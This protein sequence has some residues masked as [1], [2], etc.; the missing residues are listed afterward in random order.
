MHSRIIR[1][2][3]VLGLLFPTLASAVTTADDK[4]TLLG[5][6]LNGGRVYA[7]ATRGSDVYVGGS[8]SKIGNVDAYSIAKWNGTEW[9]GVGTGIP[10]PGL[11]GEVRSLAFDK[12]GNLFA[13]GYFNKSMDGVETTGIIK[14]NGSSWSSMPPIPNDYAGAYDI[15]AIAFDANNNLYAGGCYFSTNKTLP[16]HIARWDGSQWSAVGSGLNNCVTSIAF[17]SNGKLFVGGSF[18]FNSQ[19]PGLPNCSNTSCGGVASWNGSIWSPIDAHFGFSVNAIAFDNNDHLYIS[20]NFSSVLIFTGREAG[21]YQLL[22]IKSLAKWS[23][24]RFLDIAVGTPPVTVHTESPIV[25]KVGQ[26]GLIT[27]SCLSPCSA[28][29]PAV[30]AIRKDAAGNMIVAGTFNTADGI[31]AKGIAR[32]SGTSWS[33]VGSGEVF[34]EYDPSSTTYKPLMEIFALGE[35][36][37]SNLYAGLDAGWLTA[38]KTTSSPNVFPLVARYGTVAPLLPTPSCIVSASNT[39]LTAGGASQLTAT[40]IPTATS[41]AWTNTSFSTTT[42]TGAVSPTNTTTYSVI[43]SNEAG[44]GNM[45]S[46]TVSVAGTTIAKVDQTVIFVSAPTIVV[47]GFGSVSATSTSGLAVGFTSVTPSV[48]TVSGTTVAAIS[49]GTCTVA[50]NQAGNANYNAAAQVT[51]SLT[52]GSGLP[53]GATLNLATGWNLLGNGSAATIDVASVFG[54]AAK[55]TTVWKWNKTTSKWAFYAPSMSPSALT[56]YAQGKDYEVLTSLVP[57]D[58]FWVNATTAIALT[59]PVANG[60]T[61]IESDL[62]QGWNL[63]GSANN[64]TPSQLNQ[65]LSSSLNAAGKTIVTAWAWDASKTKWAFYAPLLEAQGGTA[66]ADYITSKDYLPFSTVLSATDG[67]WLN[68]GATAASTIPVG[69][70]IMPSIGWDVSISPAIYTYVMQLCYGSQCTPL[71]G[72]ILMDVNPGDTIT[73]SGSAN[74]IS[75]GSV[76]RAEL[77]GS[78][79]LVTEAFNMFIG[80]IWSGATTP[81]ST[82]ME[83]VFNT[84]LANATSELDLIMRVTSGFTAAGFPAV[85]AGN[86]ATESGSGTAGTAVGGYQCPTTKAVAD[87]D[88][89]QSHGSYW[90]AASAHDAYTFCLKSASEATCHHHYTLEAQYCSYAKPACL[91][92]VTNASS[93]PG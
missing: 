15:R 10:A 59:A 40:C 28:R 5:N 75:F 12:D 87:P 49:V 13:G 32:W 61:L 16:Q 91:A 37:N 85:V 29:T 22:D 46:I 69:K 7:I 92:V 80:N 70:G 6:N 60:V 26:S 31:V 68:I 42:K 19:S 88:W 52:V 65:S 17:A 71:G 64:K 53:A 79:D 8:F 73:V 74:G 24:T 36:A 84:A 4:W 78:M 43:G 81:S 77:Q 89:M 93:C 86:P 1:F 56:T 25:E 34:D 20:G 2:L 44:A 38:L 55:I 82:V 76:T 21:N 9:S 90:A 47:G 67:F 57:K 11:N 48:C 50:A 23:G 41:Y 63:V 51:Q 66:L 3:I 58:G 35:D 72:S 45:S 33:G 18:S 39:S 30:N 54:D 62:Q 14:W 27:D 83:S